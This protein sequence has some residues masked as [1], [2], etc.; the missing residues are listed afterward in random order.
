M[1]CK[2]CEWEDYDYQEGYTICRLFGDN[3]DY[4]YEN[5]K[6]EL[7]CK[8]N[9]KSLQKFVKMHERDEQEIVRQMG[10]YVKFCEEYVK[11]T[12]SELEGGRQMSELV[13]HKAD[14]TIPVYGT[15]ADAEVYLKSKADEVIS[16]LKEQVK[17][18]RSAKV[19]YKIS[20]NDLSDGLKD[21]HEEIRRL[22]R[23]II[24][25]TRQWLSA[26]DD[27]YSR[28]DDVHGLDDDDVMDWDKVTELHD[29]LNK[30]L[31]KWK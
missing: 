6:G 3:D 19:D 13:A 21:A 24:R 30:V 18:E 25:M 29:N 9:R 14:V 1:R 2:G 17:E 10:D 31:E 12:A 23:C 26:I 11:G 27:M 28:L 16:W 22:H 8:Y 15:I 5:K 4:I 20:A 7:G